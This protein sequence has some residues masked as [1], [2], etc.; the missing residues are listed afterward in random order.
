MLV[1]PTGCAKSSAWRAL[2]DCLKQVENKKGEEYVI[3]PKSIK[4]DDLYGVLDN[5]TMEW[6]DGIFTFIL[7]KI[8]ENQRDENN[9]IHWIVF[10]GDVDPEWAENLN[11]VLDDNKLLTLP[12]GERL[13]IPS[14][15]R[16]LFEV[17][18]LKYATLATVSRCG[19]VWFS[20]DI[21]ED[22]D[23]FYH[24]LQRLQEE[25]FDSL[26]KKQTQE[27]DN[28]KLR[29]KCVEFIRHLFDNSSGKSFVSTAL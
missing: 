3:D 29:Q 19:M 25:N 9:K 14:N 20:E 16:I 6:T 4:K 21:L 26:V 17:E 22:E 15:V 27:N 24:Y 10:D 28:S 18:S 12:N 23:I 7:R 8:I 1:G 2:L 5:T 11:S 13:A